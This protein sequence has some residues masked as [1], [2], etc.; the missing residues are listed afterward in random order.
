M[1]KQTY[2]QW[3][4]ERAVTK[5]SVEGLK[6]VNTAQQNVSSIDI[7]KLSRT[8]GG[9]GQSITPAGGVY[10]N[11]DISPSKYDDTVGT[12]IL[13][14][15]TLLQNRADEQSGV[16]KAFNSVV[17]GTASGLLTA[18]ETMGYL[19]DI[20]NNVGQIAGIEQVE[21]NTVSRYAKDLK[22]SL[23]SAVPIY[24]D[25][26]A[27]SVLDQFTRFSTL[28]GM[29]DS[30]IGFAI[31]GGAAAKVVK[32]GATLLRTRKLALWAAEFAAKG[33]DD[34]LKSLIRSANPSKIS[35]GVQSLVGGLITNY[36][37]GKMMALELGEELETQYINAHSQRILAESYNN[38]PRFAQEA[39]EDARLQFDMDE[40]AKREIGKQQNNFMNHNT[41]FALTDAIGIHKLGLSSKT[42]RQVIKEISKNPLKSVGGVG[43]LMVQ[44]TKE[45]IE[46]IGQNVFQMEAGY[47]ARTNLGIGTKEDKG[48]KGSSTADRYLEYA[49]SDKALLEGM[50]GFVSGGLQR[51]LTQG[52][53]DVV[54]GDPL[55]KKRRE[56][57]N[58]R[59]EVQQT[60][61]Q[62]YTED[63]LKSMATAD[64][65]R[66]EF[67]QN[68]QESLVDLVNDTEFLKMAREAA[69]FGTVGKLERLLTDAINL[70]PEQAAEK[71][72]GENYKEKYTQKLRELLD[73]ESIY[74]QH[75][76][77]KSRELLAS[78][79]VTHKILVNSKQKYED[80]LLKGYTREDTRKEVSQLEQL[81]KVL[82]ESNIT[83]EFE[84][85]TR[86]YDVTIDN[87]A[88]LK[89]TKNA[90][91]IITL[92]EYKNA[93]NSLEAIIKIENAIQENLNSYQHILN[94]IEPN[95]EEIMEQQRKVA[96]EKTGTI[97]KNQLNDAEISLRQDLEKAATQA[98]REKVFEAFKKRHE[99]SSIATSIQDVINK[100]AAEYAEVEDPDPVK[101][102]VTTY[103]EFKKEFDEFLEEDGKAEVSMLAENL[104]DGNDMVSEQTIDDIIAN[105]ASYLSNFKNEKALNNGKKFIEAL[106]KYKDRKS[107]DTVKTTVTP[108]GTVV[109]DNLEQDIES[110]EGNGKVYVSNSSKDAI[111]EEDNKKVEILINEQ[112]QKASGLNQ[113]DIQ[114]NLSIEK[115][116]LDY[117]VKRAN[118]WTSISYLFR[119][120]LV[121]VTGKSIQF[122]DAENA[123]NR[124]ELIKALNKVK[125]NDTI[126]FKVLDNPDQEVYYTDTDGR[127]ISTTWG[128]H[129]ANTSKNKDNVSLF[130]PIEIYHNGNLIG[131]IPAFDHLSPT[132]DL[133]FATGQ[134]G[135]AQIRNTIYA[136]YKSGDAT[137]I[138]STILNITPGHLI[139]SV[140]NQLVST[141]IALASDKVRIAI[142]KNGKLIAPGGRAV[143]K[144]VLNNVET[145]KEGFT[146]AILPLPNGNVAIPLQRNSL[147]QS[148]VDNMTTAMN[149]FGKVFN[150]ETLTESEKNTI[151]YIQ[152][153][154][155]NI[156]RVTSANTTEP[157]NF[158]I[159]T[160]EGLRNYLSIYTHIHRAAGPS[161]DLLGQLITRPKNSA[162]RAIS[163]EEFIEKPS[164][165]T[166]GELSNRKFVKITFASNNDYSIAYKYFPAVSGKQAFLELIT[167][168]G[169]ATNRV[170]NRK[171]FVGEDAISN[172][173]KLFLSTK[174]GIARS[175][176]SEMTFTP[177]LKLLEN[178][179]S[180]KL[181]N[182]QDTG[183]TETIAYSDYVKR[184][185]STNILGLNIGTEEKPEYIYTQ[186]RSYMFD[187]SFSNPLEQIT[188]NTQTDATKETSGENVVPVKEQLP[189]KNE[190][191]IDEDGFFPE[192][193][194]SFSVDS[195]EASEVSLRDLQ[196]MQG[197][198]DSQLGISIFDT[199]FKKISPSRQS[200]EINTLVELISRALLESP[201]NKLTS[202]EWRAILDS[203]FSDLMNLREKALSKEALTTVDYIDSVI[204]PVARPYI[205]ALV[206]KSFE[207]RA[208][209]STSLEPS[210]DSSETDIAVEGAEG[211]AEKSRFV[212]S[213]TFQVDHRLTMSTKLKLALSTVPS[214]EKGIGN[215]QLSYPFDE[216]YDRTMALLQGTEP[217]YDVMA[218][219][220]QQYA[221]IFPWIS[222][223]LKQLA[224]QDESVRNGFVVVMHKRYVNMLFLAWK[225]QQES[226]K[227]K[228][229]RS[230]S[231]AIERNIQE[232]WFNGL[233]QNDEF[234]QINKFGKYQF[235]DAAKKKAQV[236]KGVTIPTTA[237]TVDDQKKVMNN[238][239]TPLGIYLSDGTMEEI[240]SKGLYYNGSHYQYN[241]LFGEGG[242]IIEDLYGKILNA[243]LE[244]DQDE[245]DINIFGGGY[246]K[247]LIKLEAKYNSMNLSNSH[248]AG[249]KTINSYA[250][251]NQ[252][253]DRLAAL[254]S[255]RELLTRLSKLPFAKHSRLLRILAQYDPRTNE[256]IYEDGL[257][258]LNND[259]SINVEAA[260][261]FEA[262]KLND[263]SLNAIKEIASE[264][265]G[266]KSLQDLGEAEHDAIKS[267]FF[268]NNKSVKE[269]G[270]RTGQLFYLTMSNK[271][272]MTT[273]EVPLTRF[274]LD[275]NGQIPEGTLKDMVN[276]LVMPEIERMLDFRKKTN[277]GAIPGP[278]AH[279]DEGSQIFYFVPTLNTIDD[280][281]EE[282]NG[283]RMLKTG[284]NNVEVLFPVVQEA[285]NS[286]MQ[287]SIEDQLTN[288]KNIQFGYNKETGKFDLVDADMLAYYQQ[289]VPKKVS[290]VAIG[291]EVSI[292]DSETTEEYN[293]RLF[294]TMAFDYLSNYMYHNM[295]LF[296]LFVTDPAF[297]YTNKQADFLANK[298]YMALSKSVF[299]NIG[300]RL[301]AESA[302][303][304][305]GDFS[306]VGT[307]YTVAIAKDAKLSSEIMDVYKRMGLSKAELKSYENIT[308]TDGAEFTTLEEHLK[309][310]FVYNKL[311]KLQY[312][313]LMEK[314][315]A[316]GEH[317]K[318]TEYDFSKKELDLILNGINLIIN[319][320][321]QV[322]NRTLSY[323][324]NLDASMESRLYIKSA[325]TPLIPQLTKGLQLDA[326]RVRME[327]KGNPNNK[328]DR[329]AFTS[330]VKVGT[331]VGTVE[332]FDK[333][334][335]IN[336]DNLSKLP[337]LILNR[338]G[339]R[340]QQEIPFKEDHE[341]INDGTQQRELL[342]AGLLHNPELAA[343]NREY[344]D[345]YKEIFNKYYEDLA[346]EID[347][348]DKTGKVNTEKVLRIIR[349]EAI[350]RNYSINNIIALGLDSNNKLRYPLWGLPADSSMESLLLSI[351]DNR[352]RKLKLPGIS[353][354]L[355]PQEGYRKADD[356]IKSWEDVKNTASIEDTLF[357]EDFNGDLL[358]MRPTDPNNLNGEWLPAQ[359][360]ISSTL[361]SPFG[362]DIN[363]RDY[364]IQKEGK[365][366]LDTSAVPKEL[367]KGF[368][369]RIPTSS[370]S[371]MGLV[372]IVGFL[373]ESMKEMVVAA[374]DFI[375]QM[376]YDFDVD[377][378]Y[379]NLYQMAYNPIDKKF[380]K[381]EDLSPEAVAAI[382]NMEM[383][384]R[385]IKPDI[386]QS[387]EEQEVSEDDIDNIQ[388]TKE[389]ELA[390]TIQSRLIKRQTMA[391]HFNKL[392][393]IH[394]K[395]MAHP[396]TNKLRTQTVS[397][398]K[399]ESLAAKFAE[400]KSNAV[401]FNP[402]SPLY[403]RTKYV[404][405]TAGQQGV[406]VFSAGIVFLASA[407]SADLGYINLNKDGKNV[408]NVTINKHKTV[409]DLSSPATLDGSTTRL[410][411][412]SRFQNA[413]VDDE[414]LQALAALNI[415]NGTFNALTAGSMLGFTEE[416]LVSIINQPIVIEYVQLL[417]SK[418]SSFAEY[419]PKVEDSIINNLL[420]V[421]LDRKA[422][423]TKD[424][425]DQW[426]KSVIHD[427]GQ[428]STEYF[429]DLVAKE[430]PTDSTEAATYD[431][432]QYYALITFNKL[433]EAGKE[434]L[435]VQNAVNISS[436]GIGKS[437]LEASKKYNDILKLGTL[438][439][440]ITNA[441]A[442]IGIYKYDENGDLLDFEPNT[443]R[444]YVAKYVLEPSLKIYKDT[445]G[446]PLFP[447]INNAFTKAMTN[448]LEVEGK[449]DA[450]GEAYLKEARSFFSGLK[451]YLYTKPQTFGITNPNAERRRLLIDK[452]YV[453]NEAKEDG[454]NLAG[455]KYSLAGIIDLLA[456]QNHPIITNNKFL[457]RLQVILNQEGLPSLITYKATVAQSSEE[458]DIYNDFTRLLMADAPISISSQAETL[459][460]SSRDLAIDLIKNAY[461]NG[462]SQGP[463]EYIRYIP[464]Q[465]LINIGTGKVFNNINFNNDELYGSPTS[466]YMLQY[467]Q[468]NPK[469]VKAVFPV[470]GKMTPE[471]LKYLSK[472]VDYFVDEEG[473]LTYFTPS[474]NLV[475]YF[476]GVIPGIMRMDIGSGKSELFL[477]DAE[478]NTYQRIP[479]LRYK[480]VLEYQATVGKDAIA[481][482]EFIHNQTA[483]FKLTVKGFTKSS[484]GVSRNS[485]LSERQAYLDKYFPGNKTYTLSALHMMLTDMNPGSPAENMSLRPI[486]KRLIEA[487]EKY[488]IN[489]AVEVRTPDTMIKTPNGLTPRG[490]YLPDGTILIRSTLPEVSTMLPANYF[491]TS[492]VHEAT[493]AL[494]QKFV[495]D[496]VNGKPIPKEITI[497]LSKL[498][499]MRNLTSIKAK[500]EEINDIEIKHGV[501][502]LDEFVAAI[503]SSQQFREFINTSSN[504]NRLVEILLEIFSA[505]FGVSLNNTQD[506][507]KFIDD[508]VMSILD[509]LVIGEKTTTA[510]A[511][512]IV[513]PQGEYGFLTKYIE[514]NPSLEDVA[515]ALDQYKTN[516]K[517]AKEDKLSD[518]EIT[519]NKEAI[520]YLEKYIDN[521]QSVD[522]ATSINAASISKQT[523]SYYK[524]NI[525]LTANT[526]F[527]FGSNPEGRHGAGAAKVAKDN[528]GAIYGQGE[529]LQGNSYA[530]PTK[531]LRVKENNGFKSISS[532]EIINS[533]K[534][535]Y[536]VALQNPIKE[537]KIGYRNTTEK[538]LN[539]YTGLEMIEMFNKAGTPP[540]NILFSEE[541]VKT[542]KLTSFTVPKMEN[543]T[544]EESS[545]SDYA[546]RTVKNAS[547]DATIAI[548]VNFDTR[549][550]VKTKSAVESQNKKYIP[551]DANSLEITSERVNQ[552]VDSLNKVNAGMFGLT[553]NIAGN[554]IYTMK[555]KY[556][557]AQ[558]DEFTYELLKAVLESPN[559]KNR[560]ASIRTGG[561][562][563]FDEAGAKAGMK[564]GIPTIIL[565]PK[566]WIF[567]NINN[568]DIHNEIE[569]KNR[570][571]I[572][573]KSK[574]E[575][576]IPTDEDFK[577]NSKITSFSIDEVSQ[578]ESVSLDDFN[579][580]IKEQIRS[581]MEWQNKNC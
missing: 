16:L 27:D 133:D 157:I 126:T 90:M 386:T 169:K 82:I 141:D 92:P 540:N 450:V 4:A 559:L 199:D 477:Y 340:I 344:L 536:S 147:Q 530:L 490:A 468:H 49:T 400:K 458:L 17:S 231:N 278:L 135:L 296:Q 572:T 124:P 308:S 59:Y 102:T 193:T 336:S 171:S 374:R 187:P 369:Y 492:M 346:K 202:K 372:Q 127:R 452:K 110:F 504:K 287:K 257:L 565:A 230:N 286:F 219:K 261:S 366:Y 43:G 453:G 335:N 554:G 455:R 381:L 429:T 114:Q 5:Q 411:I 476:D 111:I 328:I 544:F 217:S 506:T 497:A 10:V 378:L 19:S 580:D 324:N 461:L 420:K 268:F 186:Q 574:E 315:N 362:K 137:P 130:I 67:L 474:E 131:Y 285:L 197:L 288:W 388:F 475:S 15:G 204:N 377:K 281:F 150:N 294:K 34:A 56:E 258:L 75:E 406:G 443:I 543:I 201:N 307:N 332:I 529:G 368:T 29:L 203:R 425:Q 166:Q 244:L 484:K 283:K 239:L 327:S 350:S 519:M 396:E 31:P 173:K 383:A 253:F 410:S 521:Y 297:Y 509:T 227:M 304:L 22:K 526:I 472:T 395:V 459:T 527:V 167:S 33:G 125:V 349:E 212:D 352:V 240:I 103:G 356:R 314:L 71:G 469:K 259:A 95:Y 520:A 382:V 534:K 39:I 76:T 181:R 180:L 358:P 550:E 128:Q 232:S 483:N 191:A 234:V 243:S 115:Q 343:L 361:K 392:L 48:L 149:I 119:K 418:Q 152:D 112:N 390:A 289:I 188:E 50:M 462:G 52:F 184:N 156:T 535:L 495:K 380:Q 134:Q 323:G 89:D 439:A 12:G 365:W 573:Q 60:I 375:A 546:D 552:I 207:E 37:E 233:V 262:L 13:D 79:R 570:F 172:F 385:R 275:E 508:N 254:K 431:N 320:P 379:T 138:T 517:Y 218:A 493:H 541:W 363:V 571:I 299:D 514:K 251:T 266:E 438:S 525:T 393:D 489:P 303:G 563:G 154:L 194:V 210:I 272:V 312:D 325:A 355:S 319:K 558:V 448:L 116:G 236:T 164:E 445:D 143:T 510:T 57:H 494:L 273:M 269:S 523:P 457:R 179:D 81:N 208:G 190:L 528:F 136:K 162:F 442:L 35:E 264:F 32:G 321:V 271:T 51:S 564:L 107:G 496:Y 153:D 206:K 419:E 104:A 26:Q 516:L 120:Y 38:D 158:N 54:S 70:T 64:L 170:N 209:V 373:P 151:Q 85:G 499:G 568:V 403:Q 334:G 46:E 339:F 414:S 216:I 228:V 579:N 454:Y 329:L 3:L 160:V 277:N 313:M 357:T 480:Q 108:V 122:E 460:F 310:M 267:A 322:H 401:Q 479:T 446:N 391:K 36:G 140:N 159:T 518:F 24:E 311:T 229:W 345:T 423:A 146:Y 221:P 557:Q 176:F 337:I 270:S 77:Y 405:A 478:N 353:T 555:G 409:G 548:A 42:T 553:L 40:D 537:F 83:P 326:L 576:S 569:F 183:K 428:L 106:K 488:G 132:R 371:S 487:M 302:P 97:L 389:Q 427:Y 282:V 96:E 473:F 182:L 435:K 225:K 139:K 539:G 93:I 123:I 416:E 533:I 422:F 98:D 507:L 515:I 316:Q 298:N 470:S 370:Q 8:P 408:F 235:T 300:K 117:D 109:N 86:L 1:A 256:F 426:H 142:V 246:M 205:E 155:K 581:M 342:F 367:L 74:L 407:Q 359:I 394:I 178:I 129:E 318:S 421:I 279:Y 430:R 265:I 331:P 148:Q 417:K 30:A 237:A 47:Q 280:L 305:Q 398:G 78:N 84:N 351:V 498:D 14:R 226:Y 2:D 88:T 290:T 238:I 99:N 433:R 87:L 440:N 566:G 144:G 524:G 449:T 121:K 252:S 547:A 387:S 66:E 404:N 69:E 531:D 21:D 513:V 330:A 364:A 241:A 293:D 44:N 434:I 73:V 424:D 309:I 412:M 61:L 505:I 101:P 542:G 250:D 384:N 9:L 291:E 215:V 341:T 62:Q 145:L 575:F 20:S 247:A 118:A 466:G 161:F 545:S 463:S 80:V 72:Y 195:E 567:R 100:V 113:E 245:D 482:S 11:P 551:V 18:I 105:E 211:Y 532:D 522:K 276:V 436:K 242:V 560:I 354:I 163:I 500:L 168:T 260:A 63:K 444:G 538:S 333:D 464:I 467:L 200:L 196:A 214:K 491:I 185:T 360:L 53:F 451:G 578:K 23:Y 189:N 6:G 222:P 317:P 437:F 25:V 41:I 58:R 561:Q 284:M 481:Q 397:Y 224:E 220:L 68:N 441:E 292:E 456:S 511:S 248:R 223:L 413:S 45:G 432:A 91:S 562:T 274:N 415:N 177:S 65:F 447:Y 402:L 549:G 295:N 55:G 175:H 471:T 399:L 165:F 486:V 28:R 376:G 174:D 501:S 348:N 213:Y 465:Y 7:E 249:N 577:D 503:T 198:Y 338:S 301:A 94:N 347:Y 512:Q 255:D 263:I 485:G 192:N 502:T 306:K 556:T